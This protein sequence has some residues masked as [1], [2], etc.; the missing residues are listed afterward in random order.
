M[1]GLFVAE[2]NAPSVGTN[3][4]LSFEVPGG[5]VHVEAIVRNV[6]PGEGMGL[7]FTKLNTRDRVLME[8][9]LRRLLRQSRHSGS[10][11][12]E[13]IAASRNVDKIKKGRRKQAAS[14]RFLLAP[15]EAKARC[16]HV[17]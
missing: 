9:L 15:S 10:P 16:R 3:L 1:G 14:L 17:K 4:R 13:E 7:E 5:S 12:S 6:M 2:P 8:F 11:R